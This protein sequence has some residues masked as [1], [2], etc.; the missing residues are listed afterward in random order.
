MSNAWNDWLAIDPL[1]HP[2]LAQSRD[3]YADNYGVV[4]YR[5]D[6]STVW[7]KQY[8]YG[9]WDNGRGLRVLEVKDER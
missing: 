6:E 1:M 9:V 2:V 5:V 3:C 8:G 4:W 7:S